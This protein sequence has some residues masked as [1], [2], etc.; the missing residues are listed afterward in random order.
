MSFFKNMR[1]STIGWIFVGA[2]MTAGGLFTASSFAT[3]D[4]IRTIEKTWNEFEE[5]R[6]QKA[7]ALSALR[8]EIGYGGMI[9]QFK[10]FVLRQDDSRIR[11]INAK[12]GGS[13]SAIARYRSLDLSELERTAIDDIQ[14]TLDAYSAALFVTIDLIAQGKSPSEIDSLVRISDVAAIKGLDTLDAE[15]T[16]AAGGI[17]STPSKSQAVATL[18]KAM[19][20]GGMIHNFKNMV[21]RH[22][23]MIM[24]L[25][26]RNIATALDAMNLYAERAL[27]EAEQKAIN[28]ITDVIRMYEGALTKVENLI[29][30]GKRPSTIDRAVQIDDGPALRGFA[31]LTREI[32]RQNEREAQK[33]N[34]ALV[35]VGYVAEYSAFVSL[36]IIALLIL[37]S[38]WLIR[39]QVSGPIERM[40][41]VMARLAAGKLDVE[42]HAAGQSNEI[43]EMARAVEVF[44]STALERKEAEEKIV[45]FKTTLD[46]TH[47]CIFMFSPSALKFY[48]VNQGAMEQMGYSESD[49]CRMTLVDLMPHHDDVSF[50]N[51]VRPLID[52]PEQSS[53]FETIIRH[54]SGSMFPVEVS[55]QYIAPKNEDA[56]FV[57]IVRDITERKKADKAKSE[58]V[59]TVSH[60]LRTPLTSIKGSLGLIKAGAVGHL[61]DKLRSMLDI[62]YSNSD[63]L[64]L[65]INDIL[66]MEKIEA[67]KME[68][69]I[70]PMDT[71]SLIDEAIVANKG[72]G[73]EHGVTFMRSGL[74]EEVLINGDRDRLMQVLSNLMSNAAKFSPVEEVVEISTAYHGDFIRIAVKDNGSGIPEEFREQIFQKFAQ[75][76]SSDTRKKGGTGLGLSIT[77]AIVEQHGG[78][79]DFDTET[80][81]GSTFY[82][83]LRLLSKSNEGCGPGAMVDREG[84]GHR[85]LICESDPDVTKLLVEMLEADGF[86]TVAATTA[87]DAKRELKA[88]N[89]DA[90]ALGLSLPDQNGFS[91]IRDLRSNPD[92]Q[93]LP[94]IVISAA[95]KEGEK[96]LNGETLG[97]IDWLEKPVDPALLTECLRKAIRHQTGSKPRILH[98]E[99][100]ESIL[101]IVSALVDDAADIV[102]A[103][104]VSQAENLLEHEHFDL[105][106]LDLILPDGDGE[107]FLP[108]LNKPGQPMTPVI[109]FS[110]KDVSHETA[111]SIQAALVKSQTSNEEL[112]KTIRSVIKGKMAAE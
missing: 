100:D 45:Q 63:R 24:D 11:T 47:D 65:L 112:L 16:K 64:V 79:I 82:V 90:M 61:P 55:L 57:A 89:F 44:R 10:N 110:A 73:D 9:H 86:L 92:T 18:R 59:S 17:A 52:D 34:E 70:T 96:R 38:L 32:S 20:Y 49:L 72:Y 81:K 6:S 51:L 22:D 31:S 56:R 94:V 1:I 91:L 15:V 109:V 23:H 3:I 58:F 93:G 5:S 74:A 108:L 71:I 42:I 88:G 101:Q 62:A 99:D 84:E 67:G 37:A 46:R 103:T 87:Q 75:A 7:A 66:D 4:N 77:K 76:D 102:G 97:I 26:R 25:A 2:L 40:T 98:I 80:G 21:L 29:E 41:N 111:E 14:N 13:A 33:V 83:D 105:V 95:D 19:G 36:L 107:S 39:S 27:T 104:S 60:E 106:I 48:Y 28:D 54:S 78:A 53:T 50:S 69:H 68:L 8:R 12:L 85:V 43:G 30:E 35:F